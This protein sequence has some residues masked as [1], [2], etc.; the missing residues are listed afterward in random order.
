MKFRS[1]PIFGLLVALVSFGGSTLTSAQEPETRPVFADPLL[2][3][4]PTV[5][6]WET[7]T[8]IVSAPE[9]PGL[10]GKDGDPKVYKPENSIRLTIR[11]DKDGNFTGTITYFGLRQTDLKVTGTI[12]KS[13]KVTF[14]QQ[15]D[16]KNPPHVWYRFNTQFT[17]TIT[18]DTW[19]GKVNGGGWSKFELSRAE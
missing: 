13:G 11:R 14:S 5:G 19:E 7:W 2:K 1:Q 4:K 10:G 8:G 15:I 9:K 16:E 12:E 18:D 6:E 17:G 3:Q